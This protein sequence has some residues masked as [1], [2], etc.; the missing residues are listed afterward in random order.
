M[1]VGAFVAHIYPTMFAIH[2]LSDQAALAQPE[3]GWISLPS[4]MQPSYLFME[5][6]GVYLIGK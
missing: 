2:D 3:T 1:G 6:Y 5:A 4:R